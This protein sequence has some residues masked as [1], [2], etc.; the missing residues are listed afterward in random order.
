V[1]LVDFVLHNSWC[2]STG[3]VF[4]PS[5]HFRYISDC[6]GDDLPPVLMEWH[7]LK[8]FNV[9]YLSKNVYVLLKMNIHAVVLCYVLLLLPIFYKLYESQKP[10][11]L[12][13]GFGCRDRCISA[14]HKCSGCAILTWHMWLRWSR[15][16]VLPLITQVRE[17]KHSQ[18]RQDFSGQK[19]PQHAFLWRGSKAIGPLS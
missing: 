9:F 7:S 5:A 14:N 17:F 1:S 10:R 15:G 13:M 4:L 16:S 6:W 18:C 12:Q 2:A 19:N 11:T 8:S 3:S